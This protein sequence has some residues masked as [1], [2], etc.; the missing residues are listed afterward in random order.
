MTEGTRASHGWRDLLIE[1]RDRRARM[2]QGAAAVTFLFVVNLVLQPP[3]LGT[4]AA[5]WGI[6][7]LLFAVVAAAGAVGGVVYHATEPLRARGGWRGS[8]ANILSLLAYAGLLFALFLLCLYLS[9]R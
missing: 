7:A 9:Q 3:E 4:G 6:L 8:L 1:R 5:T 2:A